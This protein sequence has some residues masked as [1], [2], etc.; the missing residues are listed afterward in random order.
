MPFFNR[1]TILQAEQVTAALTHTLA[2]EAYD[3]GTP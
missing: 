2:Q 3:C 1:L